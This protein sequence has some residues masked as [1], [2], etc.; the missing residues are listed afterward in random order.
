MLRK[1]KGNTILQSTMIVYVVVLQLSVSY[2]DCQLDIASN[3]VWLIFPLGN[4]PLH[5]A[6]LL[7]HR[8]K[9]QCTNFP[10]E[11]RF[12]HLKKGI[13]NNN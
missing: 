10:E 6:V 1:G 2:Y 3:L 13:N 9:Q 12:L 4:T 7:G 8:G 11:G 5:L